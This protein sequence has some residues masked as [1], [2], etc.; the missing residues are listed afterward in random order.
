MDESILESVKLALGVP[1][2]YTAFDNQLILFTN[3]ALSATAQTGVGTENFQITGA[4]SKW[5][6]FLGSKASALGYTKTLVILRVRLMFDP[7]QSSGAVESIK[8]QIREY[9]WRGYVECDPPLSS[10]EPEGD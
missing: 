5:S 7:P 8:E 1:T 3:A 4:S 2:D 9:E 10:S 6:D